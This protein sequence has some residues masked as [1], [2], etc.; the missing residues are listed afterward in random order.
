M[1]RR[2]NV[3]LRPSECATDLRR[4][5]DTPGRSGLTEDVNANIA[6]ECVEILRAFGHHI[7]SG[8]LVV[9]NEG[10]VCRRHPRN[11]FPNLGTA[12]EWR[13]PYVT[14]KSWGSQ[15]SVGHCRRAY[16]RFAGELSRIVRNH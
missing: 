1:Q 12:P 11:C 15:Q 3:C 5:W 16:L 14:R 8:M 4:L 13:A 6:G 2:T 7:V 9:S 10:L